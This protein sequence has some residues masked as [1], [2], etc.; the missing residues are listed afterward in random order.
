MCVWRQHNWRTVNLPVFCFGCTLCVSGFSYCTVLGA[1]THLSNKFPGC[2]FF[3]TSDW[4][5]TGG[6]RKL[7]FCCRRWGQWGTLSF[8]HWA[9]WVAAL[10]ILEWPF[11]PLV[12]FSCAH[13][14]ITNG[15]GRIGMLM[16]FWLVDV[17]FFTFQIDW[18]KNCFTARYHIVSDLTRTK[19]CFLSRLLSKTAYWK[20]PASYSGLQQMDIACVCYLLSSCFWH[21]GLMN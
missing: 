17:H 6:G 10:F 3:S 16:D 11:E 9:V 2:C 7:L 12:C 8:T 4:S 13:L 18:N 19:T 15:R 21:G 14:V 20:D 1:L 5:C